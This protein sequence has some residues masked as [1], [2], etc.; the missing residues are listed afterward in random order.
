MNRMAY[1][2]IGGPNVDDDRSSWLLCARSIDICLQTFVGP[3]NCRRI[4]LHGA[5]ERALANTRAL[6]ANANPP[7]ND[8][9][10]ALMLCF[11]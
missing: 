7:K 8:F 10:S 4:L 6:T 9:I 1:D 3:Q 11:V 5:H 2:E